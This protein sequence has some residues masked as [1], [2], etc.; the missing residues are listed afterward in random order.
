MTTLSKRLR[1]MQTDKGQSLH[2]LMCESADESDRLF[3]ALKRLHTAALDVFPSEGEYAEAIEEA[4]NAM[5]AAGDPDAIR[6]N[7][8]IAEFERRLA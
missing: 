8:E 3:N 1:N 2:R 5:A 7:A 6:A 4:T